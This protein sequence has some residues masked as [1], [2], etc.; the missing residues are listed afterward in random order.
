[1]ISLGYRVNQIT[2]IRGDFDDAI[3]PPFNDEIAVR[4]PAPCGARRR[5]L[6]R[7]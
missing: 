4:V 5:A 6:S 7:G 1:M 3:P 2:T